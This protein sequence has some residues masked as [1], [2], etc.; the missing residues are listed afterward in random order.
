[1]ASDCFWW[2]RLCSEAGSFAPHGG[3]GAVVAACTER[4]KASGD[5]E[6]AARSTPPHRACSAHDLYTEY[7]TERQYS[8]LVSP[9][10]IRLSGAA[11]IRGMYLYRRR[12]EGRTGRHS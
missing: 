10:A 7:D 2:L 11:C 3:H 12:S 9:D 1:M 8:R 4:T 5:A 6:H